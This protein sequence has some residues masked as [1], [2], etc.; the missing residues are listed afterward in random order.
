MHILSAQSSVPKGS[1]LCEWAYAQG[2]ML[3]HSEW[4][5]ILP[6]GGSPSDIDMVLHDGIHGR[7]ALVELSR[8]ATRWAEIGCGQLSVYRYL[9]SIGRGSI[10]AALCRHDVDGSRQINTARDIQSFQVLYFTPQGCLASVVYDGE[11]WVRFAK[12]FFAG[13]EFELQAEG[14]GQ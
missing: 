14:G 8:F 6:R 13:H 3:D 4:P 2:K 12:M 9:V 10:F 11:H 1:I 7:C 5:T